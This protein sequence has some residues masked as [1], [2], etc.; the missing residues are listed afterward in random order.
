MNLK[1]VISRLDINADWVGLREYKE[2]TTYH[3]IRDK[4][5][6]SNESSIDHG[7]MVEV[8]KDRTQILPTEPFETSQLIPLLMGKAEPRSSKPI[9]QIS[10]KQ[11]STLTK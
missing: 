2:N 9:R 3:V 8:L 1:D 11:L 4:N 7:I 10:E 6:L 5:P